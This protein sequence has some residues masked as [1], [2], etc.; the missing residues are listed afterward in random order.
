MPVAIPCRAHDAPGQIQLDVIDSAL[1]LLAD[2]LDEA[3]RSV[4]FECVARGQKM[5]TGGRQKMAARIEPRSDE[6]P[7]IECPLPRNVHETVRACAA[8]THDA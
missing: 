5:A 7:R 4:T 1:D 2:R 6:L 3:V 8:K